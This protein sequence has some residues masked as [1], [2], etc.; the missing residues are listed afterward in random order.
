MAGEK[1]F[2]Q[3]WYLLSWELGGPWKLHSENAS[4]LHFGHNLTVFE[5]SHQV[6]LACQAV[7][8]PLDLQY[9]LL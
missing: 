2:M 5:E 6:V 8:S 3:E 1:Q 4:N 7:Q 9:I